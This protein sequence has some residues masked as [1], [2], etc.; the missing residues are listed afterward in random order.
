V[1]REGG[2]DVDAEAVLHLGLA[3]ELGESLRAKGEFYRA[4]FD[5]LFGCRDFAWRHRLWD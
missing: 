4:F 2:V 3:D 1:A 5:E